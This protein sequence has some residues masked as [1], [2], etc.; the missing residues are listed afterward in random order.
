MY[1]FFFVRGF[2]VMF[3]VES[4]YSR[5]LGSGII[6]LIVSQAMINMSVTLD[7]LPNKGLT[8][9]FLSAGGTSLIL[10]LSAC[11]ILLNVSR[12]Q[13]YSNRVRR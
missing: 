2:I 9:P 7:L 3:R 13:T 12:Y 5:I 4:M 6:I 1:L 11:G 8:L 10:C